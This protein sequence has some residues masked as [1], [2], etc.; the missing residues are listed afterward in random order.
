MKTK[1]FLIADDHEAVREGVKIIIEREKG[2][3][4]C[5][6]AGTGT[7][8]V[9]LAKKLR[10]DVVVVD[11]TMPRLN[12]LEITRRIKRA[13]PKTEILMFTAHESEE[14]IRRAFEAGAKSYIMKLDTGKNLVAALHR[15]VGHKPFFTPKVADV[16]FASYLDGRGPWPSKPLSSRENETV[17]LLAEGNTNKEVAAVL[18]VSVK[19]TETHR[20][21]IM[22]KLRLRTFSELVHYAIR[23][24]MIEA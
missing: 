13:L 7:E 24:K 6:I 20:A 4:V 5:G 10:P 23:H 3:K 11:M 18:G 21:A 12:G 17:Q 15:L 16:L 22:R 9:S 2:W 8:A 14:L 19:T 1:R